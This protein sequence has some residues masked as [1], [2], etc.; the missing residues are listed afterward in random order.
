MIEI[1]YSEAAFYVVLLFSAGVAVTLVLIGRADR[2]IGW[3]AGDQETIEVAPRLRDRAALDSEAGLSKV[4]DQ[5][6]VEV[7]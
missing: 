6:E 7:E 4:F 5:D 3:F 1:T 2:F